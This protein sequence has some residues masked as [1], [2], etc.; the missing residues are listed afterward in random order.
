MSLADLIRAKDISKSGYNDSEIE[1]LIENY[2]A[3]YTESASGWNEV[4]TILNKVKVDG[5]GTKSSD[6]LGVNLY[7]TIKYYGLVQVEVLKEYTSDIPKSYSDEDYIE[8]EIW[9]INDFVIYS[10]INP[11]PLGQRPFCVVPRQFVA[12]TPWGGESLQTAI[13]PMVRIV[14]SIVRKHL[15]N[16][17]FSAQPIGE[18]EATRVS[19][20]PPTRIQVGRVY[21]VLASI[22]GEKA[23]RF[24]EIA[25]HSAEYLNAMSYY[26]AK[27]D[28]LSGIPSFITGTP[29]KEANSTLGQTNFYFQG[30]SRGISALLSNIDKFLIEPLL[31]KYYI[32]NLIYEDDSL[33]GDIRWD[34]KGL[35]GLF[36]EGIAKSQALQGLQVLSQLKAVLPNIDDRAFI[37]LAR[38][39]FEHLGIDIE[40]FLN[41]TQS[42]TTPGQVQGPNAPVSPTVQDVLDELNTTSTPV[43]PTESTTNG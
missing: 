42:I 19:G 4:A 17:A 23:Y 2:P 15:V 28:D 10:T 40:D 11:Y 5:L 31:R 21:P 29:G 33:K 26:L 6:S 24:T 22:H 36:E 1:K 20:D 41:D 35:S 8:C 13:E 7:H 38:P 30:A 14:N 3:G 34:A 43:P 16:I 9:T 12:G 27:A 39:L 25:S 37:E 18:V 32:R